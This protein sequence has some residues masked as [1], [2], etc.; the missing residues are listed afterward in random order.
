MNILKNC[1][2]LW[3]RIAGGIPLRSAITQF[4]SELFSEAW[5]SQNSQHNINYTKFSESRKYLTE[6]A[7]SIPEQKTPP[8]ICVIC[9]KY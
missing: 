5:V 9:T 7:S 4:A 1:S 6:K 2:L 8:E 3:N